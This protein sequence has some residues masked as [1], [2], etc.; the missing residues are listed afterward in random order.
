MTNFYMNKRAVIIIISLIIILGLL[1]SQKQKVSQETKLTESN[2]I[3]KKENVMLKP[4]GHIDLSKTYRAILKTSKGDIVIELNTAQTPN[5]VYNFVS[6]ARDNFYDKTK[7]HRIIEGFMI[8]GGDPKGDGTGGPGYK[9]EDEPFAGDYVKGAVA[10][11]NAGPDTNGSQFFIMHEDYDLP[12]NYVIFGQ[13]IEGMDVVD[14]IA[15][16]EVKPSPMGESS[17]PVEPT[18]V[19]SVEIIEE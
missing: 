15:T 11:A 2:K 19:E 6:L 3:E 5:T 16:S 18:I 7:F 8:Q 13:V 1:F 14:A 4:I 10:M 12:K 9:F 17:V